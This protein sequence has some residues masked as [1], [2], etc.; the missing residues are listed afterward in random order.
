MHLAAHLIPT[1]ERESI[2]FVDKTLNIWNQEVLVAGALVARIL[3]EDEMMQIQK[4][5]N[6]VGADPT[7][8]EWLEKKGSHGKI[9]FYVVRTQLDLQAIHI[10]DSQ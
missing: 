7:A 4:L 5:Y 9:L 8:K 6:E 10:S 2:D 1:V 3:Y